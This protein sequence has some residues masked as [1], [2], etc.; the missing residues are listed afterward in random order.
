MYVH[1]CIFCYFYL[2]TYRY[3]Y[4]ICMYLLYPDSAVFWG[5]FILSTKVLSKQNTGRS[6]KPSRGHLSCAT[7]VVMIPE[8]VPVGPLN[9]PK[10]AGRLRSRQETCYQVPSGHMYIFQPSSLDMSMRNF[11]ECLHGISLSNVSVA[12]IKGKRECFHLQTV[13]MYVVYASIRFNL[14]TKVA[15]KWWREVALAKRLVSRRMHF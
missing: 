15:V 11:Q 12:E 13:V 8:A 9:R 10:H 6:I 3:I 5:C 1:L 7:F 14:P 4:N 2:H